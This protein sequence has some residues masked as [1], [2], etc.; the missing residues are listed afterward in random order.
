LKTIIP[1]IA[2]CWSILLC[3]CNNES[4]K[5]KDLYQYILSDLEKIEAQK[6]NEGER[7]AIIDK[8]YK[9]VSGIGNDST[10]KE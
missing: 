3:S 6:I 7:K 5:E 10:Q 9:K 2:F 1:I 4:S 8:A